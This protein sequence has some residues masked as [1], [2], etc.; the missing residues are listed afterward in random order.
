MFAK[1]LVNLCASAHGVFIRA[2]NHLSRSHV[3]GAEDAR[4]QIVVFVSI[5]MLL[6]IVLYARLNQYNV[7]RV[8]DARFM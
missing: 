4:N 3:Y 1:E 8:D 2:M 7:I 6:C 5:Q